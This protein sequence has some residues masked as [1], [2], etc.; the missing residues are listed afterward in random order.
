MIPAVSERDLERVRGHLVDLGAGALT[1]YKGPCFERRLASRL[2]VRGVPS[3]GAYADLLD[4]DPDERIKLLSA[5][6][7]G[8][9]SFFRNPPV[10][11]RLV[12]LIEAARPAGP[13]SAWSAGCA[14]GEEAY[15]VAIALAD[16]AG[17]GVIGEWSVL[18]TDVDE[19]SLA[20]ARTGDYPGR[21][22]AEIDRLGPGPGGR[23]VA[24]RFQIDPAIRARVAFRRDD[25]VAPVPRRRFDL[26]SCRNVLIY[27]GA[28]GQTRAIRNL[29]S[30]LAE[31]GLLLLGKAEL[32]ATDPTAAL[33]LVDR[34]E[35]IYRR[36]G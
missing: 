6:A 18:G 7:I 28:E 10:W 16:L 36:I 35:R 32:A 19:R 26:V 24:G 34:R 22:A 31:G 1:L 21:V 23:V 12:E 25:I 27:F 14:T 29:T 4:R 2:R 11:R 33:E 17:R 15:S 8:V 9:T 5:L 30:A 20:A 13:Y 3:V